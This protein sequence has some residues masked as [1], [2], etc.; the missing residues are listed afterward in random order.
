[1]GLWEDLKLLEKHDKLILVAVV[2]LVL[3]AWKL[4]SDL[5]T[6]EETISYLRTEL[7]DLAILL[8]IADIVIHIGRMERLLLSG[9]Q[10]ILQKEKQ[11]AVSLKRPAR[12]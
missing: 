10:H 11:I 4:V 2:L 1:M 3:G 9:E 5:Q 7:I 6:E 8:L 12:K